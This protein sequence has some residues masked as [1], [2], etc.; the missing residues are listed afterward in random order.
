M[1]CG[2]DQTLP[3][4]D[5]SKKVPSW[6]DRH[7]SAGARQIEL[8]IP[9]WAGAAGLLLMARGKPPPV[10]QALCRHPRPDTL[11]GMRE[12]ME[13]VIATEKRI[14]NWLRDY[15]LNLIERTNPIWDDLAVGLAVPPLL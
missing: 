11:A 12:R 7:N 4:C 15:K 3:R 6:C 5:I 8:N 14:K 10:M 9:F 1:R 2:A 13:A